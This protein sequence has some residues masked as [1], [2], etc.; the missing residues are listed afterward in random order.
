MKRA[1]IFG[2]QIYLGGV[3]YNAKETRKIENC[4]YPAEFVRY[5]NASQ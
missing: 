4:I 1:I 5:Y 3:K 2:S